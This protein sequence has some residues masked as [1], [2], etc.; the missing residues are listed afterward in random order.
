M[1]EDESEEPPGAKKA[2]R[3]SSGIS[4]SQP[5]SL[6]WFRFE[7]SKWFSATRMLEAGHKGIF[8]DLLAHMLETGEPIELDH[9]RLGRLCNVARKDTVKRA[10]DALNSERL[11]ELENGRLWSAWAQSAIDHAREKSRNAQQSARIGARKRQQKQRPQSANAQLVKS[12]SKS[13]KVSEDALSEHSS[14]TDSDDDD[15]SWMDGDASPME[16]DSLLDRVIDH[17]E[18]GRC[19]VCEVGEDSVEIRSETTG[20]TYM[21]G[22][23]A[24][25][26]LLEG[27]GR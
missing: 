1:S 10:I 13:Q 8:M 27:A 20:E 12:Q 24:L 26:E 19:Y 2:P 9:L 11:I 17:R 4:A 21:L 6:F 18:Y 5:A 14:D 25:D 22:I 15:L 23:E 16:G 7:P 3:S